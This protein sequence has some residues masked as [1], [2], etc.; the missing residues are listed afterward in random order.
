L[1]ARAIEYQ[2]LAHNARTIAVVGGLL[3]LADRYEGLAEQLEE[4]DDDE[5]PAARVCTRFELL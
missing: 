3:R 1:R 2:K 5:G 4:E